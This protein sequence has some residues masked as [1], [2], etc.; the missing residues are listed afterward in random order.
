MPEATIHWQQ[1]SQEVVMEAT[2]NN[3]N[4]PKGDS[5][6]G[7]PYVQGKISEQELPTAL[8][9]RV[10]CHRGDAGEIQGEVEVTGLLCSG[11]SMWASEP[12]FLA[13]H[14]DSTYSVTLRKVSVHASSF[15][16]TR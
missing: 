4:F 9:S 16:K 11:E 14:P 1:P 3:R 8:P 15:A 5:S 7:W 6:Q 2:F 10:T 13:S 12:D